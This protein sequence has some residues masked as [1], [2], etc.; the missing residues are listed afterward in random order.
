MLIR[1]IRPMAGDSVDILIENGRI[2]RIASAIEAPGVQVE[3]GCGA[4]AI[5]GLVEAHTHLDKT[6]WGMPW[7]RHEQ[8]KTLGSMI[9]NERSL[10]RDLDMDPARQSARHVAMTMAKGTTAIRSHVDIDTDHELAMFD[11]V[12]ATR[13]RYLDVIDIEIVAFPQSGMMIRPGTEAL[14]DTALANGADV[15]GGLDPCGI[16]RDPKGHLDAVFALAEKHGKPIDIH[17]H[18]PGEMGAFSLEMILERTESMAMQGRVTVSHAFCL[19]MPDQARVQGLMEWIARLDVSLATTA[20]PS[21]P[22]PSVAACRDLGI[23]ICAGSDGIRDTWTPYG[24]GDMLERAMLVGLRN[25]FRADEEVG[26]A[27]ETCTTQGARVMGLDGYGLIEGG[28]ADLVLIDGLG[29]SDIVAL[30]PERRLVVS[31]GRIVARNGVVET[32]YQPA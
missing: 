18:E 28:S 7:H 26:W 9:A 23:A 2:K 32:E 10:R 22:V 15:V 14:M 11:G 24:N 12:V 17:L 20:P 4:I 8:G 16:D 27:L 21:R 5:P 31:K 25:N 30:R 6:L 19:G 1:N 3:D 13:Q 29:L